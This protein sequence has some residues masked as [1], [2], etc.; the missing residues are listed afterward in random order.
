MRFQARGVYRCTSTRHERTGP[1][2]SKGIAVLL[3]VLHRAADG[4]LA[5]RSAGLAKID[6]E[7]RLVRFHVET[8][9]RAAKYGSA[10]FDGRMRGMGNELDRD[11]TANAAPLG[12]RPQ[13][14]DCKVGIEFGR[15]RIDGRRRQH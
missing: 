10:I 13:G 3:R 7:D 5:R 8:T 14:G 15:Q 1:E 11:R 9:I 2:E 4:K 6:T 12:A